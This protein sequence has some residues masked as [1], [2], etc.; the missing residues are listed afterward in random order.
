MFKSVLIDIKIDDGSPAIILVTCVIYDQ[1]STWV[2]YSLKIIL[3][4]L[5]MKIELFVNAS[6]IT[7][8]IGFVL[9][10]EHVKTNDKL[11]KNEFSLIRK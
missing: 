2:C 8:S 6:A 7:V 4:W 9:S 10:S 1:V 11:L 5:I 3:I